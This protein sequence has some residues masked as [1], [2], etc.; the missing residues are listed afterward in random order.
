[1]YINPNNG[2]LTPSTI[3]LGARGDSYYEYL[4]KQFLQ[5]GIPWLQD[6]YLDAIDAIKERLIKKTLGDNKFVY[7]AE[8]LR[9]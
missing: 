3:T 7:V 4:L 2:Q 9:R 1:M 5:T 6:D 8:L